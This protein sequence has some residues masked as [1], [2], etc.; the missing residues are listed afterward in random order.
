MHHV[1]GCGVAPGRTPWNRAG[2]SGRVIAATPPRS[3]IGENDMQDHRQE[4]YWFP[5]KKVGWGWGPPTSWHGWVVLVGY[6]L[7][8]LGG[9]AAIE[10][11]VRPAIFLAYA[12]CL[13]LVLTA[14]CWRKGEPPRWRWG[15]KR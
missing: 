3:V 9:A 10:P 2:R 5:A 13:S 12:I 6:V 1:L 7:L 8:L 14:I 4:R 11:G 15:D